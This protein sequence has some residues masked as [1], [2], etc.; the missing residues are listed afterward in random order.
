MWLNRVRHSYSYHNQY[1]TTPAQ[2]ARAPAQYEQA[3]A[4][5]DKDTPAKKSA[6]M[7]VPL[8]T[9]PQPQSSERTTRITL[10]YY[11]CFNFQA[12]LMNQSATSLGH[13]HGQMPGLKVVVAAEAASR[14]PE[15]WW[16]REPGPNYVCRRDSVYRVVAYFA[17]VLLCRGC[18]VDVAT[19]CKQ[20]NSIS[21]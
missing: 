4:L 9:T 17:S 3:K 18:P 13:G 8:S 15:K 21:T 11:F 12:Q 19:R 7:S 1:P 5:P 20:T 14:G 10:T 6:P 16:P 2:L